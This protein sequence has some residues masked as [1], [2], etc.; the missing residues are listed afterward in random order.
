MSIVAYRN[1][2]IACDTAMT[3]SSGLFIGHKTKINRIDNW[4]LGATGDLAAIDILL[5]ADLLIRELKDIDSHYTAFR[6][7]ADTPNEVTMFTPDAK[8]IGATIT[9]ENNYFAIG[10]GSYLAMGAMAQGATA[11]E[12]VDIAIKHSVYCGGEMHSL[13]FGIF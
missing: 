12:A 7:C 2:I 4:L 6:I 9:L 11:Q 8:G 13:S 1:G 10:H 5:R 3:S